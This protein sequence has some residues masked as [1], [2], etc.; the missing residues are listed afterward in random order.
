MDW[1]K[2]TARGYKIHLS[3]GFG[4]T[5]T[6]G[7]TV[8]Q[9]L[10]TNFSEIGTHWGRV[11]QLSNYRKVSNIRCTK[12]QNLNASR[13]TLQLSLPNPLKPGVKLRMK[14]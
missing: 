2:T 6:R 9:T 11:I 14:M 13:P 5:Y 3:F 12:S 1:A 4:A 8:I 10:A 7:F